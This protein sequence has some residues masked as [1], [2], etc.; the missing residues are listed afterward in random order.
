MPSRT[1]SALLIGL[2][3]LLPIEAA[4]LSL[5]PGTEI[6]LNWDL[7]GATPPPL[8]GAVK[9]DLLFESDLSSLQDLGVTLYNDLNGGGGSLVGT[10]HS[11]IAG[12]STTPVSIMTTPG[13]CP[14][15]F[16]GLFSVGLTVTIEG[17]EIVSAT[18]MGTV[19]DPVTGLPGASTPN[20]PGVVATSRVPE[21][22]AIVLLALGLVIF[23][24][25]RRR[26][27]AAS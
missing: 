15:L 19:S 2:T 25:I 5:S 12:I 26:Q 13:C 14:T 27:G 22:S 16:D 9:I 23:G 1:L 6:I 17:T 8:Y 3:T 18:A 4:A 7:T 21:P 24:V 10:L 11:P 20:V